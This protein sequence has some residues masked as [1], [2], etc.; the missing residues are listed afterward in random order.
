MQW[1]LEPISKTQ[2]EPRLLTSCATPHIQFNILI[3]CALSSACA[4]QGSC[5]VP[6]KAAMGLSKTV[7]AFLKG[8]T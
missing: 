1:D 7:R 5:L 2:M 8:L 4:V 6:A 3:S